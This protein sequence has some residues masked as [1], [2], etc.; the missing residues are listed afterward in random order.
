MMRVAGWTSNCLT[1]VGAR[2]G[3]FPAERDDTVTVA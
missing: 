1:A 2:R 3:S